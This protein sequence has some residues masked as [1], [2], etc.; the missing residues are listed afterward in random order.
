MAKAIS[1][2]PASAAA[3]SASAGSGTY[4]AP[5]STPLR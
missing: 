5:A 2:T 4:R 3:S 1:P